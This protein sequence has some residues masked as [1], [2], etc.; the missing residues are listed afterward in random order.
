MN[1]GF[2]LI[3]TLVSL[4]LLLMTVLFSSRILV[5]ALDQTRKSAVR[6]RLIEAFDYHRNYLSSLPMVSPEL[7]VGPHSST[8]GECKVD[9]RV[10]AAGDFLKKIHLVV[11]VSRCRLR[12]L[13]YRS[14]F[15]QEVSR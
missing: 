1:K 11:A 9:W 13:L 6:F 5:S 3:E 4:T 8:D 10:E 12:L 14:Q 7:S 2:T 15:I